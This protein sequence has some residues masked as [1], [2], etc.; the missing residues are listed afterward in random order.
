VIALRYAAG[1]NDQ[2]AVPES[3]GAQT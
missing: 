3:A 2:P 1:V